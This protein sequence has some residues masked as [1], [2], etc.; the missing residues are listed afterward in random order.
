MIFFNSLYEK[1]LLKFF[2]LI[3]IY[4]SAPSFSHY[5]IMNVI[6]LAKDGGGIIFF[7]KRLMSKSQR[8]H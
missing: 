4:S 8:E 3:V 2:D 1:I 5:S 6:F 7:L